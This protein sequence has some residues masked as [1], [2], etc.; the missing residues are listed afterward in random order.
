MQFSEND[1]TEIQGWLR[2]AGEIALR[3]QPTLHMTFKADHSPVTDAEFRIESLIVEKILEKFPSHQMLTEETGLVQ[4]SSD[5]LWVLDPV[6]GTKSFL[7]GLPSWGISLGLLHRAAPVAGF[8]YIPVLQ[9]MFWGSEEG[10][11]MNGKPLSPIVEYEES[12]TFLAVS[13]NMH[14]R[15]QIEYPRIQAFGS[16]AVHLSFLARGIAAGVLTRRIHLWDIAGFLPIFDR[17]GIR[18]RYL[19]GAPVDISALLGGQ[20]TPEP[21]LAA[22]PER[23]ED[24]QK[25]I[26]PRK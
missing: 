10:V 16:T 20:K 8:F 1:L 6:D 19:S 18:Y 4:Q 22:P 12:L 14:L 21:I 7:R 3:S 26:H 9:E 17:L 11:F 24:L 5:D 13:A 2:Q 15:Y 23:W 25:R